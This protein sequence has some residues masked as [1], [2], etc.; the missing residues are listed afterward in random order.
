M[1]HYQL[2]YSL[3]TVNW[4]GKFVEKLSPEIYMPQVYALKELGIRHLMLTGYVTVEEANF[5]MTEET[6]RLGE[7]I[8]SL[9]MHPCQHHGLTPLYAPIGNDQGPVQER[10]VQSLQY[11]A[12]LKSPVIVLHPGIYYHPE[13]WAKKIAPDQMCEE[14]LALH[15]K[16]A[17]QEVICNNLKA[18][19]GEAK[20]LGVK[21]ALEN[22]VDNYVI[23]T[24]DMLPQIIRQVNDPSVGFCLD[25]GH[26][27]CHD[28]I[29]FAPWLEQLGDKL[30]TTHLHDNRGQRDEHLPPGFGIIPWMD[31]IIALRKTGYNDVVNFESC[32]WPGMPMKEGYEMAIR[33]WRT[34]EELTIGK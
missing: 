28:R 14:Q 5:D 7:V 18:V 13:S 9:D 22:G 21:I 4:N 1:D 24:I 32:G 11:T 2:S 15:G 25:A 27:L 20:R 17:I 19:L 34:C 6:L 29:G 16:E 31:F 12:N 26:A 10:L 3:T 23:S 33:Y 8:H 30:L